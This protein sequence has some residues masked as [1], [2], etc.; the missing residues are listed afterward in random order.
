MSDET[1]KIGFVGVGTMG[2]CAHL[3][4]YA[5]LDQC[6][7]TAIAELRP[8]LAAEVARKYG[9]PRTYRDHT[10]MLADEDLDGIVAS[11][12]YQRHGQIVPELLG[13]DIPIFTE[14]PLAG[15]APV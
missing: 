15:S 4:N 13:A 9:V 12:P 8:R 6:E 1:V 5:A 7:V 2:Q 14:K 10:E 3:K 11:Q